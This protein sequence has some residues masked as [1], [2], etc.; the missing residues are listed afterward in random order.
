MDLVLASGSPRRRDLLTALGLVFDV[1]LPDV[2]ET[3]LPQEAPVDYVRRVADAKARAGHRP[4]ALTIAADT[5]V[6]LDGEILGKPADP[7][8]AVSML[9]RLSGRSHVVHT[10][11]TGMASAFGGTPEVRGA[12]ATAEVTIVELSATSIRRYVATGEPLDKAGAYGLQGIGG[13]FVSGVRG[14]PSAVVGLPLALLRTTCLDLGV[15]LLELAGR[16]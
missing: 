13:Q 5:T 12:V 2:D 1:V 7:A 4:G 14:D 6:V 8:E 9:T 10:A 15:D 16:P 11:V 3:P